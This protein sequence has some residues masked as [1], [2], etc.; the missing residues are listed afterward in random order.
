METT[1][2]PIVTWRGMRSGDK[3]SLAGDS[4]AQQRRR[5]FT[6]DAGAVG[7][8]VSE[9]LWGRVRLRNK[10]NAPTVL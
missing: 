3:R 9:V 10:R 5:P 1:D 4:Q 7:N 2:N 6:D 8:S